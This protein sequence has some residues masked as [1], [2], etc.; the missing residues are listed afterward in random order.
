MKKLSLTALAV[1]AALAGVNANAVV[2][3]VVSNG[4]NVPDFP[5]VSA[6]LTETFL[7]GSSAGTTFIL[8]GLQESG[9]AANT[10]IYQYN[11]NGSFAFLCE[12]NP[13]FTG[14]TTQYLLVHKRDGGG[15]FNGVNTFA[16][17]AIGTSNNFVNNTSLSVANNA[18][19]SCAAPVN[20]ISVCTG[21]LLTDASRG[22]VAR[23]GFSDVDPI[24][25][26]SAINNGGTAPSA[27]GLSVTP[28]AT[29]VFGLA[30]NTRLRNAMQQATIL[31]GGF[32]TPANGVAC[33]VG[34]EREECM[35]SLTRAQI[36]S[37]LAPGRVN[38]WGAFRFGTSAAAQA[39]N[40]AQVTGNPLVGTVGNPAIHVCSRTRGSGTLAIF[41]IKFEEAPCN[42][43]L[44]E[45]LNN[46]ASQTITPTDGSAIAPVKALHSMSGTSD[47]ES[48]LIGLNN[49][50]TVGTF[51]NPFTTPRWAVGIL[52][53]ERNASG[54]QPFRFIKI[55][56]VSPSAHNVAEG[57]YPLFAELVALTSPA[58]PL[59]TFDTALFQ[60]YTNPVI[61]GRQNIL[62]TWGRPG[63]RGDET[64]A[65]GV[66]TAA[67]ANAPTNTNLINGFT[68]AAFDPA[69]PV[70]PY[71]HATA[72]GSGLNHCRVPTIPG[73]NRAIPAFYP[74]YR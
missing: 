34:D 31:G 20:D 5:V 17:N 38:S 41:N 18:A 55:D 44:A 45:V 71:S 23:L 42:G 50:A 37:I 74:V 19:L 66:A 61:A 3:T 47:V 57:R 56:N 48:C 52:S 73:G 60:A 68:N 9:C 58:L 7:T 33:T 28:V 49:A 27:A 2:P 46:Q 13:A 16:P 21:G 35:P 6:S 40:N 26:A 30:V 54:S 65:L 72:T 67:G 39:L 15:S 32:A 12:R 36:S 62:P 69:R 25:F 59:S 8:G 24:Q 43:G 64:G 53:V 1:A 22:R 14:A 29:I 10:T 63:V 70:N 51:T 4:T 11:G